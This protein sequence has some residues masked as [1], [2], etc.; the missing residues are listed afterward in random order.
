MRYPALV[1]ICL[2]GT[3]ST[4]FAQQFSLTL[5]PATTT[6]DTFG[7]GGT[8]TVAVYGDADV[9]THMLGG[10]FA[11]ESNSDLVTD[12]TWTPASWSAFNTDGGYAGNGNYNQVIFGQLV[13]PGVPPFD[14]PAPGS[15]LGGLIGVFTIQTVQFC[16]VLEFN[17]VAGS[18]FALEVI[19]AITGE[20]WR[21][22]PDNLDLNGFQI[23]VVPAPASTV[24]LSGAGLLFA[25]RRR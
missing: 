5:V 15:E 19:D 22:E 25:R 6:L 13:I 1:C 4:G 18:P 8:L 3:A 16:G 21:S 7:G 9:G 14:V 2:A 17:P 24:L 12:I 11:I 23:V 10:A 20:T